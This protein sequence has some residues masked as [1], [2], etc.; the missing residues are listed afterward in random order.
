ML[1]TQAASLT[2]HEAKYPYAQSINLQF[3][4]LFSAAVSITEV[5]DDIPE[6]VNIGNNS[7]LTKR[8]SNIFKCTVQIDPTRA[9][10]Q[11]LL[12]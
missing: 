4:R 1:I 8:S 7:E 10:N 2:S 9:S 11:E 3:V 12:V 6:K 5:C